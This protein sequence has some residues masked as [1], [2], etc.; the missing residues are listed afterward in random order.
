MT[1]IAVITAR[2]ESQRILK[3]NI[4][5]FCG[6]PIISYPIS[7]ALKSDL[8]SD[9]IVSTDS[10]EIA[11]I[12]I[13]YGAQVPFFRSSKNS[14]DFATTMD[15]IKEVDTQWRGLG[16]SYER[17]CCLYPT[18]PFL[19]SKVLQDSFK[20]F[21]NGKFDSLVPIVEFSYPIQRALRIEDHCLKWTNEEYKQTRS[22]DLERFY[23]DIGQ[24]YWLNRKFIASCSDMV[25]NN[26][27]Y[28]ISDP[29]QAQDIDTEKD[30]KMAE[31]KYK[32]LNL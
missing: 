6:S 5:S 25:S 26:T 16:H 9:I 2:G 23:H 18:S 1:N 27:G 12:S 31:L 19:N 17:M 32:I 24:F 10:E 28:Y 13:K 30:W 3:K 15:V 11:E 14:D 4:R 29:L 20:I 22:Q 7:A 21:Q 8:F